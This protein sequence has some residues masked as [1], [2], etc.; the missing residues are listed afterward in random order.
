MRKILT[1]KILMNHLKDDPHTNFAIENIAA[2]WK[3]L[4]G[5]QFVNPSIFFLS[6]ILHSRV[7]RSNFRVVR[8]LTQN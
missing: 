6:K 2:E 4:I 7:V 8:P 5:E 3:H 1:S